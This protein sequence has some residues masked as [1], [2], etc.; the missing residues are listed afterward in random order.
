[1]EWN[2]F[3]YALICFAILSAC[4]LVPGNKKT[5]VDKSPQP[6]KP[7]IQ[8][9]TK[10]AINDF[11]SNFNCP[12]NAHKILFSSEWNPLGV[13]NFDIYSANDDGTQITRLT[14]RPIWEGGPVWSPDRCRI[15]YVGTTDKTSMEDI[16]LMD[17]DGK[18]RTRIT[19]SPANDREPDWSPDGKKDRKSTR[20]NS[21]HHG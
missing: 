4:S 10:P 7:V 9:E 12:E 14:E 13:A 19:S 11:A 2:R 5:V 20:L 18:N 17:P 3:F 1:M 21:S 15:V 16:Y 6:T 8:Q